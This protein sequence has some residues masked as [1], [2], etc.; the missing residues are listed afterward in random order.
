MGHHLVINYSSAFQEKYHSFSRYAQEKNQWHNPFCL[1]FFGVFQVFPYFPMFFQPKKNIKSQVFQVFSRFFPC[2]LPGTL[3]P[4]MATC[5]WCSTCC[6]SKPQRTR[7]PRMAGRRWS[8]PRETWK[9]RLWGGENQTKSQNIIVDGGCEIRI[10]SWKFGGFYNPLF[11]WGWKTIRLVM[12]DFATI[13]SMSDRIPEKMSENDR[14]NAGIDARKNVRIY[15][16][17]VYTSKWYVRNYV[18]NYVRI[19]C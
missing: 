16:Y 18:R 3:R 5:R 15:I 14:Y 12:Q 19:M 17:A 10:T 7:P 4:M 8:S 6:A 9:G 13:H 11:W 2:F 1:G